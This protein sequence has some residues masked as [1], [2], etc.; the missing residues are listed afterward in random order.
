MDRPGGV[1]RDRLWVPLM[2]D[3]ID[4]AAVETI[5]RGLTG[6]GPHA[7]KAE[8][9][10]LVAELHH[11]A[12]SVPELIARTAELPAT[13]GTDDLRVLVVDR[14]R[15]VQANTRMSFSILDRLGHPAAPRHLADRAAGGA[16]AVQLGGV[17]GLVSR[18]VLGQYDPFSPRPGLLLVAQNV[19][20]VER[21]LKLDP[22]DF[23]VWVCLHEQTHRAQFLTAPWLVDHVV[24]LVADVLDAEGQENLSAVLQRVRGRL[25][26]G[27]GAGANAEPSNGLVLDLA[28]GPEAR[29]AIDQLTAVMSLLEGHADVMMDLAAPEV[30]GTLAQIRARF[31]ARRGATGAGA[32]FG[33]LLGLDAKLAQYRDGA[34]FCR[35][36]IHEAGLP[37]LNLVWQQPRNLPRRHELDD[38]RGWLRRVGG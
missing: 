30:I 18:R 27:D 36:V 9:D 24:G 5:G 25:A 35:A 2:L 7:T 11:A 20:E 32:R 37:G 19:L 29:R 1:G 13:A 4:R 26:R 28:S 33:R 38:P 34:A 6:P 16:R 10:E 14:R 23:R 22:S 12:A 3:W 17:L 31:E 8:R 21:A 15:W